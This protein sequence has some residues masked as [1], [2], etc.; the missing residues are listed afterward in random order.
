MPQIESTW[1]CCGRTIKGAIVRRA[2]RVLPRSPA[3]NKMSFGTRW[4]GD[5]CRRLL[6][7]DAPKAPIEFRAIN[8]AT[9]AIKASRSGAVPLRCP[10]QATAL[11]LPILKATPRAITAQNAPKIAVK[12]PIEKATEHVATGRAAIKV[13]VVTAMPWRSTVRVGVTDRKDA[14]RPRHNGPLALLGAVEGGR[15]TNQRIIS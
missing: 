11:S 4:R 1:S 12:P 15:D 6:S 2:Q 13:A 3:R 9:R 5:G 8:T 14:S 10:S 7:N